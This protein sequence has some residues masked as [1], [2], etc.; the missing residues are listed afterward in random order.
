MW[1]SVVWQILTD[2]S[3]GLIASIIRAIIKV[4]SLMMEAVKPSETTVNI[5]QTTKCYIP[6][7]CHLQFCEC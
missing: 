6:E 1:H 3:D 4:I 2:V 5:Y 7:D